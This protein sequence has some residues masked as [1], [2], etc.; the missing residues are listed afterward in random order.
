MDGLWLDGLLPLYA[1]LQAIA[2]PGIVGMLCIQEHQ[3]GHADRI[4]GALGPCYRSTFEPAA[5]RLATIY[6]SRRLR[7][8]SSRVI[9]LPRLSEVPLWQR[10]YAAVEPEQKHAALL[11][12]ERVDNGAPFLVANFHLDA[13]GTNV[14]RGEQLSVVREGL[15]S[16]ARALSHAGAQVKALVCGDTNAFSF[17]RRLASRAL[18]GMLRP[19][20]EQCGLIDVGAADDRVNHFFKRAREPKLGQQIAV[21]FGQFGVDFPCRY[22]VLCTDLHVRAHGQ[23]DTADSDHDIVWATVDWEWESGSPDSEW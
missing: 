13:A 5:P 1:G 20:E 8:V 23:V 19:L 7:L 14:H 21:F 11:G 9:D 18:R 12:F 16:D 22:D 4:A 17:R 3:L 10:L 6:D 2:S 15:A